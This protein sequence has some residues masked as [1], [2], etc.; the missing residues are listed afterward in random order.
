MFLVRS[1]VLFLFWMGLSGKMSFFHVTA[2]ALSALV[3]AFFSVRKS[4]PKTVTFSI[5]DSLLLVPRGLIYSFWLL[6]QILVA[7]VHVSLIILKPSMNLKPKFFEH[8]SVLQTDIAKTLFAN[9][10]TL[11]P[12][13]ITVDIREN[14]LI[15]HRIDGES[16][17]GIESGAMERAIAK[18]YGKSHA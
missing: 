12:G 16:S 9:S 2:G 1:L 17:G 14:T 7:A 18:I 11:T 15:I 6:W 4:S 5:K 10:I 3:I 8:R 13:T